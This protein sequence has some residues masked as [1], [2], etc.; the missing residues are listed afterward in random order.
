MLN[1]LLSELSLLVLWLVESHN[2]RDAHAL[3]DWHVV[4]WSE[5]AIPICYI[6]R[7]RKSH[8]LARDNPVQISVLNL[9]KVL[10]LLHIKVAVV[11]PSEGHGELKSLEAVM[12]SATVG[13]IAH[14]CVTVGDELVVVGTEGLPGFVGGLFEHDDHEGSHEEGSIALLRVLKRSVV[15]NLVVLV[16]LVIHEFLKFLAEKM[17][18]AEVKGTKVSKERLVHKVVINAEVEGVL[19]RLGWVLVTDPVES[20][21]DD[22]HRLIVVTATTRGS[23]L[24]ACLHSLSSASVFLKR[25]TFDF[26]YS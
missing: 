26:Y 8:E 25:I 6:E 22:L 11:V 2:E 4:V 13:T 5:G 1:A 23:R 17:D 7:T 18:L 20:A 10:V 14:C 15:V 24:I 12:V 16:L 9:L 21:G 3:E 19:P